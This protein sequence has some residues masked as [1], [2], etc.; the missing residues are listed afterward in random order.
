MAKAKSRPVASDDLHKV[1]I[2]AP[3]MR[4]ATFTIEGTA[5]YV[6]EHFSNKSKLSMQEK[7][8]AGSGQAKKGAK[9]APK[10][11][12][13]ACEEAKYKPAGENW[14]NGALP[15]TAFR[16]AMIDACRL[17]D[18]KM[19]VAKEAVFVVA[20]GY[21]VSDAIPLIPITKGKPEMFLQPLKNT[22]GGT[23]IRS[24]PKWQ[25]GWQAKIQI[26]Y[27]S[28]MF[29]LE[30]VTNLLVR[31]G[32]QVGIGAGRPTSKKCSGCGWGTWKVLDAV[33]DEIAKV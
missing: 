11:F 30:D 1:A 27:D 25:P 14:P 28:D 8:E 32:V 6:Q 21:D 17:V 4:I 33:R 3:K 15:A 2:S 20:E 7:M 26:R 19:T 31:A 12:A 29:S 24:R 10:D 9:K 22:N 13:A 23:D 5:P 16:T 18:F